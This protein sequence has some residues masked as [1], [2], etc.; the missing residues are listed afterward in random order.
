MAAGA[1]VVLYLVPFVKYPANPPS[2]GDPDTITQAHGALPHHDPDLAARGDRRGAPARRAGRA[3]VGHGG[4]ARRRRGYLVVVII[5]GARCRRS[6]RCRRRS[7]RSRCSASARRRSACSSCSGRRSASSSPATAQR[8]MT[9]Q[10]IIRGAAAPARRRPRPTDVATTGRALRADSVDRQP[11]GRAR[12]RADRCPG[13]LAL[14]AG[15]GRRAGARAPA[16][17]P[18]LGAPARGGRVRRAARQRHRRAHL[19]REPADP[20][21]PGDAAGERLAEL[22]D[23]RQGCCRRPSTSSCA[24]SSRARSPAVIPPRCR[25]RRRSSPSS[26][27]ALCADPA[28]AALSGRFLF[29]VDDGSGL[30]LGPRADVALIAEGDPRVVRARARR[31]RRPH[32]R[33]YPARPP[34]PRSLA[35]ARAFLELARARREPVAHRRPPGRRRSVVARCSAARAQRAGPPR[36][37]ASPDPSPG[38]ATQNDGR[39]A[40]TALPPL[41]RL[42]PALLD[43]AAAAVAGAGGEVRLSPWRTLTLRDVDPARCRRRSRRPRGARASP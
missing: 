43:G 10:T 14:H 30:A 1:F 26:I 21:A 23:R 24:T 5:A 15:G 2:V 31:R 42:D 41:G 40:V 4:D 16:R 9:G 6:T 27:A 8:V 17:R 19:A 18:H 25:D 34:R 39:V 29:A 3:L 33:S 12:R 7:R 13:V 37:A 11:H 38:S 32:L 20:R 35:A 28:L 22:L 36:G